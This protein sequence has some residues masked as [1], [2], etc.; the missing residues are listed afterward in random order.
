MPSPESRE[1]QPGNPELPA[2]PSGP[3]EP[4]RE[5]EQP[6]YS[7]AARFTGEKPAG[8]AY[9]QAQEVIFNDA[10]SEL[11]AY[12]LMLNAIY[13]VA[14]LGEQPSEETDQTL[15]RILSK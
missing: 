7:K 5:L 3:T 6:L 14:V 9:F 2:Q 15:T 1:E 10:E 11:S 4:T 8:R 12:R 13:H